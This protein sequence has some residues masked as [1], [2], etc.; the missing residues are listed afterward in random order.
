MHYRTLKTPAEVKLPGVVV[1][2]VTTDRDVREIR[3]T[4][5]ERSYSIKK[6]NSYSDNIAVM[7]ACDYVVAGRHVVSGSVAGLKVFEPFES[8][9]D[10]QARATALRDLSGDAS[11][12]NIAVTNQNV[13]LF[14]DGRVE[15]DTTSSG[16]AVSHSGEMAF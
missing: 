4:S 14:D 16:P 3:L 11:T 2:F 1:E 9:S 12:V 10:A 5:G 8:S 6:L 7:E 15:V 13:R